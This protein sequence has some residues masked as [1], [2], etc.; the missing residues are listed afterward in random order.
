MR[1]IP[2]ITI[3]LVVMYNNKDPDTSV[4][5]QALLG[6]AAGGVDPSLLTESHWEAVPSTLPVLALAFVMQNVVPV[7]ASQLE[8]RHPFCFAY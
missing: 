7:I 3:I 6:V 2:R 1:I 5:L 8:A 4:W